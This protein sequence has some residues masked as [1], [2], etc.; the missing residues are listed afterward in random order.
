MKPS[1]FFLGVV[2]FLGVLVPGAAL[3]FLRSFDPSAWS[4]AKSPIPDWLVFGG[5]A[6]LI[7]QLLLA[8][9]EVFNDAVPYFKGW[10]FRKVYLDVKAF[11]ERA[12]KRLE[13]ADSDSPSSKFHSAL[14]YL[15]INNAAATGEVDHHMADYKLLRNLVLVLA[16][17]AV[18]RA[19]T[20]QRQRGLAGLELLLMIVCFGA[21][22]RM[23]NWAQLLAFQYVCLIHSDPKAQDKDPKNPV[24]TGL[25]K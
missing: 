8:V 24:V 20:P 16:I 21:Y 9:T 10:I 2:N 18:M 22:V 23:Y 6:Y 4:L 5:F 19:F 1:D 14:S 15:R 25:T 17:D 13:L 12:S 7:G 3:L 11:R